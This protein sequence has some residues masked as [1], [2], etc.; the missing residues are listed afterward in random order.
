LTCLKN[1][2]G[3][4]ETSDVEV[5]TDPTG[6][7]RRLTLSHGF[8]SMQTGR[9]GHVLEIARFAMAVGPVSNNGKEDYS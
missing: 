2:S 9:I 8:G 4:V 1:C 6:L 3:F 5:K 7:Q